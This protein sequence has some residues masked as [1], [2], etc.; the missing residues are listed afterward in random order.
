MYGSSLSTVFFMFFLPV[1]VYASGFQI[2][3]QSVTAVGIAGAHIASTPGPDSSYYNPANMIFLNDT[4]Q[5][6]ASLTSL[7]LPSIDYTDSRSPILDGSSDSELFF[8]PLLHISSKDYH[9]FRFGFSLTSPF[10]LAKSWEQPFP[11]VTSRKFSLTVVEAN[12]T[13][14]FSV[15]DNFSIGGGIRFIY[16]DGEVRNGVTAP[17]FDQLAPLTSLSREMD[18]ND[19]EFGYNLAATLR[20]TEKWAVAATYRSEVQLKLKGDASLQALAGQSTIMRYLGSGNLE[21]SLPAVFSLATSYSFKALTLE[22]AWNHTF[23]SSFEDLDFQY[24]QSFSGTVFDAFDRSV[25]K[26]WNDSDA[27]RFGATFALMEKLTT[28]LG[29]AYD[30][31][32]VPD[33]TLG[34]ELPDSDSL[35]YSGGIRYQQTQNL[36]IALSYMYQYTTSRTV[37]NQ[38]DTGLPGVDGKFTEGGA[39]AVTVGLIYNF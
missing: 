9:D 16:G 17:P 36:Q 34:F 21:V 39:Q 4:W 18:G 35:M 6:E 11:A 30:Q 25:A 7:Y 26:N 5:M 33:S 1:M 24:D 15:F 2:P 3:N 19:T 29:F 20:P 31:T 23:W 22:V 13:V 38:S 37:S 8:I 14:A 10:G 32:P 27:I 28:T 12:P